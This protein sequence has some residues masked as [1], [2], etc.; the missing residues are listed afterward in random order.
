MEPLHVCLAN[1]PLAAYLVRLGW[2]NLQGRPMVVGGG[3]ERAA[4]ALALVG[5]V[6][7]GPLQLFM[8]ND[9][10][11]YFGGA[12]WL[13]LL[14]FYTLCASL[15][16]LLSRP[17]LGVYNTTLERLQP[18]LAEA[19]LQLDAQAVWLGNRLALPGLEMSLCLEEF[20]PLAHLSLLATHEPQNLANWRRFEQ[21]LRVAV[22]DAQ[23]PASARGWVLSAAGLLLAAVGLFR[24]AGDPQSVVQA[25]RDL[26]LL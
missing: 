25:L 12:V 9:A 19:A 6:A 18:R 23:A 17:R 5:Y 20:R 13:L 22:A 1:L 24:A 26:L 4:L 10:A 15:W 14:A 16:N 21:S 2:I 8:P 7:V 11:T 3:R